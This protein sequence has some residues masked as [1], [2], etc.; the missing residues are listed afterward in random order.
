M[1]TQVAI[2]GAG[3]AGLMLGHLLHLRG[4]ESVILEARSRKYAE[5]RVRAGVLEQGTVDLLNR[6]G[7]G[8]R[9]KREGLLH[10]G[11]E[12]GFAGKRHRI[13]MNELTGESVTVYGQ[14]EVVKDLIA[15]R[16]A[17]GG[18]IV[19]EAEQVNIHDFDGD[20]P[21]VRYEK[22]GIGHEAAL[23]LHCG[24]RWVSRNLPARRCLKEL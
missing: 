22:D 16:L 11:I 10:H 12:L 21:L 9:M 7:L 4:V 1:K 24:L 2:I 20:S 14:H 8:E 19:F 13:D 5:E 18:E 3:P 23:R 17:A 6:T 15:A